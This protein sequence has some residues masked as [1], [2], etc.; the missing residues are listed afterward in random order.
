MHFNVLAVIAAAVAAYALGA[1]WYSPILFV[2]AWRAEIG[3]P[4][5]AK[6]DFKAMAPQLVGSFLLALVQAGMF[7]VFLGKQ[8]L[9][10]GAAYGFSAGLCWVAAA[11][12]IIYLYEGRSLR[13]FLINGGYFVASFTLYGVILSLWP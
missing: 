7:A 5:D 9:A 1:L 4:P 10:L 13:L 8:P 11:L 6:T 2:K 12:G 3:V